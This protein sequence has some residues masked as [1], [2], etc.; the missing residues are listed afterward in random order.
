MNF[1]G[2][3]DPLA[4]SIGIRL[5]RTLPQF[6]KLAEIKN[7]EM[8]RKR[9]MEL[10]DGAYDT[11]SSDPTLLKETKRIVRRELKEA[12]DGGDVRETRIQA[13]ELY[14]LDE[15]LFRL[16]LE[17]KKDCRPGKW[18]QTIRKQFVTDLLD[19]VEAA[20]GRL[21]LD[22]RNGGGS[23]VEAVRLLQPCL[24]DLFRH[25]LG[26]STLKIIKAARAK[27]CKK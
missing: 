2:T 27:N 11:A 23:L 15:T 19:A 9:M 6:E 10:V 8:F 14:R 21:G 1:F 18:K 16:E 20:G 12:V 25:G 7:S 4:V 5:M 3:H 13:E 24:P 26:A 17:Q 22:S